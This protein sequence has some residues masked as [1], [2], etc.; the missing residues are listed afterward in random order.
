MRCLALQVGAFLV[1]GLALAGPAEA[2]RSEALT[3]TLR[4][5]PPYD[6]SQDLGA[7]PFGV[8]VRQISCRS[9][10]RVARIVVRHG[11]DALPA[12]ACTARRKGIEGTVTTC[13]RGKQVV[14]FFAGG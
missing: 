2:D 13:R 1:L 3:L 10:K 4:A 5:C 14:R 9:G 12:W 8:R 7:G 11:E 6:A